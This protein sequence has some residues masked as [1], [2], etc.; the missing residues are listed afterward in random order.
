MACK[1][2]LV[3]VAKWLC[4]LNSSYH[5]QIE[6]NKITTYYIDKLLPIDNTKTILLSEIDDERRECSVCYEGVTIQTK[7]GH[8]F[9]ESCISKHYCISNLCPYCR[10]TI[11]MFY[12]I[13]Q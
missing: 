3:E 1:N 11:T 9:C 10:K 12:R 4:T 6:N 2:G 5:I 7:C 8:N 13:L